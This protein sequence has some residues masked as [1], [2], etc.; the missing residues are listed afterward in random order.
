MLIS[1]VLKPFTVDNP[2]FA[3]QLHVQW[4][5]LTLAGIAIPLMLVPR[6]FIL[7]Q[8]ESAR[9]A[10]LHDAPRANGGGGGAGEEDPF[11]F[12]DSDDEERLGASD[13]ESQSFISPR[14]KSS[15]SNR[16]THA[17]LELP[18]DDND[19]HGEH[20]LADLFIHQGIETIEFVLGCVSNTASYLRLWALSLAHAQLAATFW[21]LIMVNTIS[22]TAW[23]APILVFAAYYVFAGVTIGVMLMM[24]VLECF[25]H[26]LRLHW[27]E[28]QVRFFALFCA[29]A[30]TRTRTPIHVHFCSLSLSLFLSR[31][32]EQVLP[33]RWLR[34][35]SLLFCSRCQGDARVLEC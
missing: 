28:F 13:E 6:P 24:D 17:M 27:V 5:L 8:R 29:H 16:Q 7:A 21:N 35:R 22:M 23:Y 34:L 9:H 11:G 30:H 4:V 32:T 10:A 31:L 15:D 2:L 26:A 33:R 12:D 18:D 19:E 3:N 14:S 20:S 1:M 25:L